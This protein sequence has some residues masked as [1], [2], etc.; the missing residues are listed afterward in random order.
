MNE[1]RLATAAELTYVIDQLKQEMNAALPG[2]Y[3]HAT[4]IEQAQHAGQLYVF[5]QPDQ[6]PIGF[7]VLSL[8][9]KTAIW[10][11]ACIFHSHRQQGNG[12]QL[13]AHAL[14]FLK[15]R[16]ILVVEIECPPWSSERFWRQHAFIDLPDGAIAADFGKPLYRTTI[17][18]LGDNSGRH[19]AETALQI[20]LWAEDRENSGHLQPCWRWATELDE[21][22]R[23]PLPV[24]QPAG[25]Q[26]RIRVQLMGEQVFDGPLFELAEGKCLS[27][28]YLVIDSLKAITKEACQTPHLATA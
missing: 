1:L 9:A 7:A 16:G 8:Y 14:R 10:D 28:G 3:E 4:V 15:H 21:K 20:D 11:L 2:L 25:E 13:V 24:V 12:S 19:T 6:S 17:A 5:G 23:I 18:T 26:W 22:G 27:N